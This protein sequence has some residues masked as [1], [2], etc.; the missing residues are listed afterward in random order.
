MNSGSDEKDHDAVEI[1]ES[2]VPL[3]VN[4]RGNLV[5]TS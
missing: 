4:D 1:S 3:V 5:H 2:A